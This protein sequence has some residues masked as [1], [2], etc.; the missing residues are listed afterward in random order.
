VE[1]PGGP[2]VLVRASVWVWA[3]VLVSASVP[4]QESQD[5]LP[6]QSMI[7]SHRCCTNHRFR[8]RGNYHKSLRHPKLTNNTEQLRPP[9]TNLR[10]N[11]RKTLS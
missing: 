8:Q 2:V 3:T 6:L 1:E 9:Q 7:L 10:P 11:R 5:N 4:E